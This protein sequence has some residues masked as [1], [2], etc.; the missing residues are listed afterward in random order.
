MPKDISYKVP[1]SR[2]GEWQTAYDAGRRS[3]DI[4][5]RL[6]QA[7]TPNAEGEARAEAMLEKLRRLAASF[8][9]ELEE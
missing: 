2:K 5:K 7:G 1:E 3:L 4:L 8:D 9:V 6:R